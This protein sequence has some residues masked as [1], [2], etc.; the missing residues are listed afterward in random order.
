MTTTTDPALA[1]LLGAAR[2]IAPDVT[3][4]RRR[5]HRRPE[6]G[7]D[8][9]VTQ[10]VIVEELGKIGLEGRRGV[11]LSSVTA[12]I[13]GG[14]PGP[15]V[16][17]RADMD[18]LPLRED[19]GLAFASGTD[20][21]MHAC[22][23]DAHMAMLLGAARLLQDRRADLPGRV[24][25]MFQPGEEGWHGARVMLEEGLLGA[26]G[27]DAQPPTGAFAIHISNRY[28][29]GEVHLKPG[30]IMASTDVDPDLGPRPRRACVHATSRP[31]PDPGRGRDHPR[32]PGDG[33]PADQRVRPR[34]RDDRPGQRRDH[35]QHHPRGGVPPRHDPDRLG[36]GRGPPSA[37]ASGGWPRGSPP[38]TA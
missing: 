24:I 11:A 29:S 7:M 25:L 6:I 37:R 21:A 16:V 13:E 15:T 8:L 22:G 27:A 18:A 5:I 28:R 2:A 10:D 31:R 32:P 33:R 23:H 20:G 4:I 9:P 34:G 38:P 17:L 12:T 14:R 19:T 35:E 1:D 30:P 26:A 36:A 3:A